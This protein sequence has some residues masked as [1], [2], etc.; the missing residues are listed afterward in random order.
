MVCFSF[1]ARK[2]PI[3]TSWH[4]TSCST[5]ST[6][7][8]GTPSEGGY[9]LLFVHMDTEKNP[10]KSINKNKP[11]LNTLTFQRFFH[12]VPP[13]LTYSRFSLIMHSVYHAPSL[14]QHPSCFFALF[15]LI[16]G[17]VLKLQYSC[18]SLLVLCSLM[19]NDS[20]C[21]TTTL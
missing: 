19:S 12:F 21:E 20:V 13:L 18:N 14:S 4:V 7:C 17:S 11:F 9:T 5:N 8:L 15:E 16:D 6:L 3:L 10:A 1:I 2:I